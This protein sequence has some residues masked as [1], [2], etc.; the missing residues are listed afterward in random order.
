[1]IGRS[2]AR[3]ISTRSVLQ[4]GVT[5]N[6]APASIAARQLPA[7]ITVPAPTN[8]RS[9]TFSRASR[10]AAS[11]LGVVRVISVAMIPP[12][13][14]ASN[15]GTTC[16]SCGA[17]TIATIPGW[18]SRERI[19]DLERVTEGI[20]SRAVNRRKDEENEFCW[21]LVEGTFKQF[22]YQ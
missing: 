7:S 15:I 2:A 9:P 17:R 3:A 12:A 16:V 11:A 18:V 21:T 8:A 13:I 5:M 6:A 14:N 4:I 1:M 22:A 20:A 19:S 10:I